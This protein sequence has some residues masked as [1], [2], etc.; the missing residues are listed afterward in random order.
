MPSFD[1]VSKTDMAEV[2]N[3]VA[4]AVREISQRFDFKGS[5]SSLE[6]KEN[7][8][9][10]LADDALKLKQVQDLL[11]TYITRRKLDVSALDFGKEEKA[12]GAM[13]RQTVKVKQGIDQETAKK[14]SKAIKDSKKKVQVSI[15][16]DELRVSGKK[17]D[18][19]QD[20]IAFVKTLGISQPLQFTNFRD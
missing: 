1:I 8:I 4:G 15:Q 3:A 7:D 17:R 5:K 16:G 19:L 6:L 9:I 12:A 18:D 2:N 10:L 11:K 20:V 14:I 13:I